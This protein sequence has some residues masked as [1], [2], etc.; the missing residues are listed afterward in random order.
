[1][2]KFW[3]LIVSC[4]TALFCFAA[5][6]PSSEDPGPNENG[7]YVISVT[8]N[9]DHAGEVTGAGEYEEGEEVVLTATTNTGY[10]FLGWY[11]GETL[12]CE[13]ATYVFIATETAAAVAKWRAEIYRISVTKN[14]EKAG[15]ATGAGEYEYGTIVT[16][17]ATDNE[18]YYFWVWF[19]DG[20]E[21]TK[22]AT[23]TITVTE[24][25]TY[26]ARWFKTPDEPWTDGPV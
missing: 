25:K 5:C 2:K 4:L 16:L 19:L 3:I 17:V 20:Q 13:D 9:I 8:K 14:N 18:G 7:G 11:D 6:K 22:S 1:M 21:V 12:L 10:I 24:D 15:D 23:L 26:E